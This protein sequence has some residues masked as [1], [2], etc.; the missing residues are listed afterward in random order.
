MRA[1][2]TSLLR[3][4]EQQMRCFLDVHPDQCKAVVQGPGGWSR[5][6]AVGVLVTTGATVPPRKEPTMNRAETVNRIEHLHHA[7]RAALISMESEFSAGCMQD[8]GMAALCTQIIEW[9]GE[10][11]SLVA[12][13]VDR[14]PPYPL[15]YDGGTARPSSNGT[16][17]PL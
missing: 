3:D 5:P 10:L 6:G 14:E 13:L 11:Q 9:I 8:P 2:P 17:R 16:G 7:T 15:R 4:V 1:T 12:D